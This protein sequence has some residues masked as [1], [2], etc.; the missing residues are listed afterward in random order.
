M[1]CVDPARLDLAPILAEFASLGY[2]RLGRVVADETVAALGARLDDIMNARVRHEGLFF[3]RDADSGRYEDLSYGA[4]WQG[5]RSDYRK[6]EKLEIDPL[7]AA[8]LVNPLYERIA[9]ALIDGPIALYRALVFTKSAAGGTAL[10]WHQDGGAFWGVDRAPFLQIWL[11]LD[12][13][14]VDGGC[15]EVLPTSHLAGLSTPQGGVILDDALRA[16][17]A[18]ARAVPLPA[19]AGEVILIHNHLWH[20]SRV[21]TTGRRRSALSVCLMSAATRCLRKKRAPRQFVRLF[22]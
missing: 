15:V 14:T 3:Q 7:F 22:D 16:A 4:G 10:P 13:C 6:V 20:R 17:E 5:P 12:D 11:A 8:F 2:A 1:L 9:R 19:R 18:E 21:N